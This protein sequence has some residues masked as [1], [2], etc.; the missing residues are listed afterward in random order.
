[1]RQQVFGCGDLVVP[2]CP[3]CH[4]DCGEGYEMCYLW[5]WKL[6]WEAEVCCDVWRYIEALE[7]LVRCLV[8]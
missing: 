8:R 5:N 4:E 2:H 1:M 6:D 7:K 3:S